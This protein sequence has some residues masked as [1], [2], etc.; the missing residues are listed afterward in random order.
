MK[1]AKERK[2]SVLASNAV[3][4]RIDSL[5]SIVALVTI[6]GAHVFTNASW[7]DP[8]GGL[9]ISLMV[10]QAGYGNTKISLL[11]LADTTV[12]DELKSSVRK[13]ATKALAKNISGQDVEIRDIQ[14]IKSGQNYLMD[15]E[16]AV[17]G[18]WSIEQSRNLEETLREGVGS[19]VRG[20]RRVH[21]RFV[22]SGIQQSDF[23]DE[24]IPAD[25]SP[26]GSP[27]PE[28]AEL[29]HNH[30]GHERT[31]STIS[32]NTRKRQ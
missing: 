10:I 8:V 6:G 15:V 27:E 1:V 11:E 7:L 28:D 26:R 4:H 20:V 17:P 22:P 19:R 30:D 12:D 9:L 24:F 25:V 3:H 2:S 18:S 32:N 13:A 29:E 16:V 14:G 5:T 23:M 21:I 31:E